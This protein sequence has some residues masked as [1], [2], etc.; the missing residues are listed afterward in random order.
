MAKR[1]T[2]PSWMRFL[3]DYFLGLP[4]FVS[5]PALKIAVRNATQTRIINVTFMNGP[6]LCSQTALLICIINHFL[7]DVNCL[8]G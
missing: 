4:G 3:S 7:M 6:P 2:H 8:S 1:K 5:Y